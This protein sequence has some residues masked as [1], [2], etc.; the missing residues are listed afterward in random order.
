MNLI[1]LVK[2]IPYSYKLS[3]QETS[4]D[5]AINSCC[6]YTE[7]CDI[8]NLQRTLTELGSLQVNQESTLKA[9]DKN[10]IAF[11]FVS[12]KSAPIL[13]NTIENYNKSVEF[14][15][16]M[17]EFVFPVLYRLV[18]DNPQSAYN[19][20]LEFIESRA[21]K[22][23]NQHM[24]D[25][26]LYPYIQLLFVTK[27]ISLGLSVEE[28]D[29][30]LQIDKYCHRRAVTTNTDFMSL[31]YSVHHGKSEV[32]TEILMRGVALNQTLSKLILNYCPEGIKEKINA[33]IL[34]QIDVVQNGKL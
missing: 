28:S 31:M 22:I 16:V 26:L 5:R 19:L 29:I 11:Q 8:S 23:K 13:Y 27:D 3:R 7:K 25:N 2:S 10:L 6:F 14:L 9:I 33:S 1:K 21:Y 4:I 34:V 15:S 24:L 17:N 18:H 20:M 30:W 12:K 32:T